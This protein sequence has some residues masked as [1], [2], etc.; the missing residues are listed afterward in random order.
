MTYVLSK[1]LWLVFSPANLCLLLLVVAIVLYRRGRTRAATT[2]VAATT[3]VLLTLATLPIGN[4]LAAPMEN[5]FAPLE[6]LPGH[7]D[8]I[9]VLS[10]PELDRISEERGQPSFDDGLERLLTGVTL[11]RQVTAAHLVYCGG[12]NSIL[13]K[14]QRPPKSIA[15]TVLE[16]L[17]VD[18][19]RV[20]FET[21]SRNTW[22]NAVYSREL[23][24]PEPDSTWLLVTSAMHMPRAMGCFRKAGW[25]GVVAYPVDYTTTPG[26]Q[27]TV[28]WNVVG[29][30]RTVNRA[31]HGW[32]GLVAYRLMGRTDAVFPGPDKTE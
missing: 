3:A 20:R 32:I 24:K 17:G 22:K 21:R 23:V 14:Q 11:S 1:V 25:P 29:G 13:P 2:I 7:V 26:L 16:Q 19:T 6:R 10:G 28:S 27:L 8:G 15:A 31:L 12:D 4:W 9:I 5:R 30:L 18:M